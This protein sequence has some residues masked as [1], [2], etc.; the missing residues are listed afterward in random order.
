M[1]ACKNISILTLCLYVTN[2]QIQ[3]TLSSASQPAE[4]KP[5]DLWVGE[6]KDRTTVVELF[7]PSYQLNFR[8][9]LLAKLSFLYEYGLGSDWTFIIFCYSHLT[10]LGIIGT[11]TTDMY[12]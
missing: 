6:V 2:T 5:A 7:Q 12:N 11:T 9:F 10:L 4:A 8:Y 1:N 3:L